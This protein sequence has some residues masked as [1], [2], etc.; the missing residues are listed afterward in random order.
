M[1]WDTVTEQQFLERLDTS[2]KFRDEVRRRVLSAELIAM[3]EN[4]AETS[5]QLAKLSKEFSAFAGEQRT[6]NTELHTDMAELK[7]GQA[8]IPN[9]LKAE[10]R[11]DVAELKAGQAELR[12]DVAELKEGQA[13]LRTDVTEL[14]EGQAEITNTLKRIETDVGELK[15]NAAYWIALSRYDEILEDLNLECVRLLGREDLTKMVRG[16][17]ANKFEWGDR[18]SFYRAD[19][20]M[21]ATEVQA[22]NTTR[23]V[24]VEASYT[25]D[26][27]DTSRAIRNA[28]MLKRCTGHE[29]SAVVASVRNDRDIQPV[30]DAGRVTWFQL[31]PADFQAQ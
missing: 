25:G 23:Y 10:L 20:V 15:G 17:G 6:V 1:V 13:E 3:P 31:N 12:T 14:K 11:T 19:L 29:A 9:T 21:E 5:A 16:F 2:P 28:E 18:R 8:E 4:L 27:R 26:H 30:I 22:P 7:E 24:A